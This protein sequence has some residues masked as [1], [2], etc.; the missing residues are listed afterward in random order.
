MHSP[1]PVKNRL[2]IM[3]LSTS[4]YRLAASADVM[5]EAIDV[6]RPQLRF[7]RRSGALPCDLLCALLRAEILG[8]V[9][10][11]NITLVGG[12][13]RRLTHFVEMTLNLGEEG[14]RCFVHVFSPNRSWTFPCHRQRQTG[15]SSGSVAGLLHRASR[16][17]AKRNHSRKSR[18]GGTKVFTAAC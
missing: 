14:A 11:N 1:E 5:E 17:C 8:C 9:V 7:F 6:D 4:T 18:L 15:N 10:V 3:G 12:E 2:L 16:L 13:A